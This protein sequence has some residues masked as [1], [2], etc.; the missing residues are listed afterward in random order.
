MRARGGEGWGGGGGEG[1]GGNARVLLLLL[2]HGL[3]EVVAHDGCLAQPSH[4]RAQLLLVLV[5]VGAARARRLRHSDVAQQRGVL[6]LGHRALGSIVRLRVDEVDGYAE[7]GLG[8]QL[9]LVRRFGRRV[10]PVAHEGLFVE[11]DREQLRVRRH[12]GQRVAEAVRRDELAQ[13]TQLGAHPAARHRDPVEP[14][15]SLPI[16]LLALPLELLVLLRPLLL[17]LL[18]RRVPRLALSSVLLARRRV[19]HAMGTRFLR[20]FR[21]G[22]ATTAAVAVWWRLG[23]WR[24]CTR[25]PLRLHRSTTTATANPAAG[26]T[27][28]HGPAGPAGRGRWRS[29]RLRSP[30]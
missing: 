11:A 7:V 22:A 28:R 29:P 6:G 24:G 27:R 15:L 3:V 1:G 16:L 23:W 20:G 18:L 2:V 14:L 9:V 19:F 8:E 12:L 10:V 30:P 13:L 26:R 17:L 4:L 21:G 5:R 25:R